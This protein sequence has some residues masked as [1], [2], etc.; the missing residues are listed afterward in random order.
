MSA[1]GTNEVV[2]AGRSKPVVMPVRP[3]RLRTRRAEDLDLVEARDRRRLRPDRPRRFRDG[4][5]RRRLLDRPLRAGARHHEARRRFGGGRR[6]RQGDSTGDGRHMRMAAARRSFPSGDHGVTGADFPVAERAAAARGIVSGTI[7]HAGG[8]F[9]E[10]GRRSSDGG[11][12]RARRRRRGQVRRDR[13]R[14]RRRSIGATSTLRR[15]DRRRR[16]RQIGQRAARRLDRRQQ[17]RQHAAAPR[18]SAACGSSV[19]RA[20]R[21]RGRGRATSSRPNFGRSRSMVPSVM[22]GSSGPLDDI[23]RHDRPRPRRLLGE[24]EAGAQERSSQQQ[25]RQLGPCTHHE[26]RLPAVVRSSRS[27]GGQAAVA[28]RSPHSVRGIS[29]RDT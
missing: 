15:R 24:R 28:P 12:S 25:A 20:P 26:R 17:I 8:G 16:R 14:D 7:G 19:P 2:G 5:D 13:R 27:C 6:R 1:F 22:T 18:R 3:A 29:P 4:L 11:G 9:I 23:G 21:T 10:V